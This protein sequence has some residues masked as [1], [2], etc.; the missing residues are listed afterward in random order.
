MRRT[1][2]RTFT[3]MLAALAVLGFASAQRD[4]AISGVIDSEIPLPD[5]VRVGVQLFD[6]DQRPVE[7]IAS[8]VPVGGTFTVEFG[9][10]NED[11][12]LAFRSGAE[13]LPG[14]LNE[15]LV[16]PEGVRY[17]RGTLWM[18]VDADGDERWTRSV[19]GGGEPYFLAFSQLERPP[20]FFSLL[21]VDRE[22][23]MTASGVDLTL[24]PGWNLFTLR[25]G[26][27]GVA[28]YEIH[29]R[30]GDAAL[31]VIDLVGR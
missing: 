18:Y 11:R 13:L 17:V 25:V 7:E 24:Q 2:F 12:L 30:I 4:A 15:Y 19:S 16:E 22:A 6:A 20:G 1:P 21:Y 29:D 28:T 8:T 9:E 31:D 5:D 26:E 14:L 27:D 10:V 23:R 3:L